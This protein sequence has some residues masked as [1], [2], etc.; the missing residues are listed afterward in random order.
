MFDV[1]KLKRDKEALNKCVKIKDNVMYTLKK[2][3]V[4]FPEKFIDKNM[5][6]LGNTSLVTGVMAIIDENN[7]YATSII[8]GRITMYPNEIHSMLVDNIPYIVLEIE[9]DNVFIPNMNIIKEASVVFD[10]YDLFI[11]KGK[12]PWYLTYEDIPKIFKN[13]NKYTGS[14]AGDNIL[15]YEILTAIISRDKN[16]IHKEYRSTLKSMNDLNTK[17]PTYVGLE[18]IWYSYNT[19][20]SKVVGNYMKLGIV[21][22]INNKETKVD[23]IENILRE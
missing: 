2:V 23:A 11:L 1:T 13:L 17:Q 18:N 12:I 4:M 22:A 16:D 19:T 9:K 6:K 20:V 3:Y 14:K 10:M 8:A 21:S 5:T 7:N 15:T